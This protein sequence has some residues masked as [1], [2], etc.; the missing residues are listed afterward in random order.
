MWKSGLRSSLAYGEGIGDFYTGTRTV[1]HLRCQAVCEPNKR[2][3]HTAE[4]KLFKERETGAWGF[5]VA[6]VYIPSLGKTG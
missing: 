3:Q 6:Y 1:L 4:K 5:D 2:Y